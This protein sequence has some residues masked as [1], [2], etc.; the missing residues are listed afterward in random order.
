VIA[1]MLIVG[2]AANPACKGPAALRNVDLEKDWTAYMDAAKACHDRARCLV[3]FERLA[4]GELFSVCDSP[5]N[6][7]DP[8]AGV[9]KDEW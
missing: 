3:L 4:S 5:E 9:G 8:F 2:I 6:D 7:I 1:L